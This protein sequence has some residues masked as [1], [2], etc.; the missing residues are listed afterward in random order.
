ML[1]ISLFLTLFFSVSTHASDSSL[2]QATKAQDCHQLQTFS[3]TKLRSKQS[4]DFCAEFKGKPMLIVNTASQ[5][6]YTPQFK[7][8]EALHQ[9]YGDRLAVVGFPSNDF[10]QEYADTEKVA[11]VC[12][13]NYGVTF[14][15]LEPS[16]VKGQSANSIF[17]ELAARSGEAPG[18]NF[19]KYLVSADGQQVMHFASETDPAS[20]QFKEQVENMLAAQ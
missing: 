12:Y 10:K 15:M 18:W 13:V 9:K 11:D 8:L 19:T 6:G 7:A 1:R 20:D 5:C 3:A 4:V 17:K 16:H 14:T 2:K